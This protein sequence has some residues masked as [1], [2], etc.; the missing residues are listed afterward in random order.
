MSE[1]EPP[2]DRSPPVTPDDLCDRYLDQV[3][4]FA[5]MVSGERGDAEDL[6]QEAMLRA[7]RGLPS[8]SDSRGAPEVWLWRIVVNTARDLGRVDR[9]RRLSFE[10][11]AALAP[12]EQGIAPDFLD[13]LPD[14]DLIAAVCRLPRQARAVIALRFGADLD[15]TAI[16]QSLG[17]SPSSARSTCTR[18]VAALAQRL[19]AHHH[20]QPT[21]PLCTLPEESS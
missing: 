20:S 21:V 4:R 8:F 16:G 6:A 1:Y 11:W 7:V 12:R 18:A 3:Y 9:R 14:E 15:F 10:R 5:A 19:T 2:E 13:G 17:I